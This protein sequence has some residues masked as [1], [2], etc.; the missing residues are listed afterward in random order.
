MIQNTVTRAGYIFGNI[1]ARYCFRA[2]IL[3][4]VALFV[5][6]AA[7]AQEPQPSAPLAG[8]LTQALQPFVDEHKAAGFV[9]LVADKDKVLDREPI[10]YSSLANKTPMKADDLF[11]IASMTKSFTATALMM[12]VDEGKIGGINDPVEK[13]LPEFKGQKVV[14]EK[15]PTHTPQQAAHPI[16]IKE[17]LSHT[18]GIAIQQQFTKKQYEEGDNVHLKREVADYAALPLRFQPGTK[19]EYNNAGFNTAGR[20]IEVVSGMTYADFMQKRLLDPLGLK[21]TVWWPSPEQA[22]RLAFSVKPGADKQTLEDINQYTDK[23][24]AGIYGLVVRELGNV[25]T[26]PPNILRTGGISAIFTYKAHYAM[27]AGGLYS[28]AADVAKFCRMILNGGVCNGKRYL[29]ENA[30]RQMTTDYAGHLYP[31]HD[32]GYGQGWHLKLTSKDYPSAGSFGHRG[33][34]G[35]HMWIDPK[36]QLVM[37]LLMQQGENKNEEAMYQ[38]FLKA[39]IQKY[40]K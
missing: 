40:G 32:S 18:S 37:V 8:P 17:I 23:N 15:D 2:A 31:N 38:A 11:W 35:T 21:D 16:T 26:I 33:A 6:G 30:I 28:T 24:K 13:Y 10:G 36:T 12:L 14:D 5:S 9:V 3:L 34:A 19:S 29:S 4:P 25:S 27:P 39:A 7:F 20:I 1:T 22:E